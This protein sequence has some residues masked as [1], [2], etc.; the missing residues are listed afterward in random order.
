M[1]K[2]SNIPESVR[3]AGVFDIAAGYPAPPNFGQSVV[4]HIH[5]T[6]GRYGI[7]S[8]AYLNMD[9]AIRDSRSNAE[10]MRSDCGIMECLESRQKAVALLPWHIEPEDEK[11]ADQVALASEMT[12]I[13]EETSYFT[14]YRRCILE[15]I[16]FGRYAIANRF[17]AEQIRGKW[18]TTVRRWEPRHG[19]KLVFRYEDGEYLSDPDQV[20][21]RVS[22]AFKKSIRN[23]A[24]SPHN[25]TQIEATEMGLVYWL[26]RA[27]RQTMVVHKHMI[28]DGPFEDPRFAGKIHGVGIRDR[29]Y[30]T[31]YAMIECLQRVI[32]YLDRAAM[33]IEIWPYPAGNAQ[34]KAATEEA[35][36]SAMGG[37]RT[38]ILA[39]VNQVENPEIYMPRLIEPGLSGVSTT[40]EII[41]TFFFHK[42][43]R[44]ILGQTLTSEADATGLGSGVADAHLA[45]LADILSY[46][47]R[48]LEETLSK[49][50]LRPLQLWNFKNSSSIRLKLKIDTESDNVKEK[51]DALQSSWNMGLE[52]KADEVYR[53]VGTAKPDQGDRVLSN[54]QIAQAAAAA[55]AGGI[56]P[57]PRGGAMINPE[58]FAQQFTQ[59]IAANLGGVR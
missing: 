27:E 19:D 56:V 52:I 29:I 3:Q 33:G 16:W 8:K 7:A 39:P 50:L 30:W 59:S 9:E 22:Q 51:L 11:S 31:W 53:I 37:G 42:I 40:M 28:E 17:G 5:T 49:Q 35:A 47:A 21:I 38:V 32:E 55:A 57:Q 41:R 54:P 20:G 18:R 6:S 14:E 45:T 48:N 44:Y 12:S 1:D 2:S 13:L 15:S 58:T 10:R 4:E 46:D 24:S 36:F 34:A 43:K 25:R 23:N 26:N